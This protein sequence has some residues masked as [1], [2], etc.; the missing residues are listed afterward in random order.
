VSGFFGKNWAS[1][2][3]QVE[4]NY[5]RAI[6][7][8]INSDNKEINKYRERREQPKLPTIYDLLH[9]YDCPI[10]ED[11]IMCMSL[12]D[13]NVIN[14]KMIY[15]SWDILDVYEADA[16]KKALNYSPFEVSKGSV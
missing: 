3:V 9:G 8:C 1:K 11:L 5:T 4:K 10:N 6:Y 16:Y 14:A 15:E 12:T 13:G 7:E 2:E